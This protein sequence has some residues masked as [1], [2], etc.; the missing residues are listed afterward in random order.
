M[1][2]GTIT[3]TIVDYAELRWEE[4]IQ[5]IQTFLM[6]KANM[7]SPTKKGKK[8]KAH[9]IP[10]CRF[11]KLIISHLGRIHNIHQRSTSPFHL[12]EEDLR[13]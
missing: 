5:A 4:F 12:A 9:V 2:W 8:D 3:S 13:L 10:Y 7:G 1:L 6:D 11:T